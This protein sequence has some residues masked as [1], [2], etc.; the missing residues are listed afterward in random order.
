MFVVV[1]F[2][3]GDGSSEEPPDMDPMF[4]VR[5]WD[6]IR[7]HILEEALSGTIL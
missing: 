6:R 7:G 5:C 4:V 1:A 2:R 3:S